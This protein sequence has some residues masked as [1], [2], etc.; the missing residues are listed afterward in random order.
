M[1]YSLRTSLIILWMA[2][3]LAGCAS[4]LPSITPTLAPTATS[5]PTLTTA[6]T[7]Q[8]SE[9]EREVMV[10]DE[11][12][13]YLLHIPPGLDRLHPVPVVMAFHGWGQEPATMQLETG[14][15]DIADEV[16]FLIVYPEGIG[17]SWNAGTCCGYASQENVDEPAFIREI[18]S[19]LG[20]IVRVD[21]KRIYAA[22]FSNGGGLMYRLACEMPDTFA[23]IA[24]VAGA[25]LYSPCQPQQP[26]SLIIVHGLA[27]TEAPYTG[28][29]ELDVPPV[30]EVLK[31]WAQ[32]DGCTDPPQAKKEKIFTYSVYNSCN[33]SAAVELYAIEAGGHS[34]PSK[35]VWPA[36]ETIW[37][38]FAAHPKP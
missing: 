24:A 32:L 10:N 6:P 14:F 12:R 29:G 11:E 17:G 26:I 18:L 1:I 36:T 13:S 31:T 28:G 25:M 9:S 27:D 15:D 4:P 33:A 16:G 2:G 21:A 22:G 5:S 19:D 7:I 34:W 3:L 30:E 35:Y 23:A 20:T 37:D 38:F 8:P